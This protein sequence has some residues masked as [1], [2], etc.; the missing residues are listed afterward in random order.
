MSQPNIILL[1]C[2][3]LGR[4]LGCYGIPTVRTP[5][6][7][8][9]AGEGVRFTNAFCTA[10]LCSPSRAG[11]FTG[12]YPHQNGVMGL[13]GPTSGWELHDGEKHLAQ[14]LGEA[15]Y[16]CE[17][18]GEIHE[19]ALPP[20]RLGFVRHEPD[21]RARY[22]ADAAIERLQELAAGRE[23]FYLQVGC[24]EPHRIPS[25]RPDGEQ[26]FTGTYMQPDDSL[27]VTVPGYLK[28]TPGT[29]EELAELQGAV[30]HM[31]EHMGRILAA[32]DA[33][34]LAETTLVIFTTDHGIAMPRAKCSLYDPGIEVALLLRFRHA[35][36]AGG[37]AVNGLVSNLDLL[38][39]ILQTVGIPLPDGLE[40]RSLTPMLDGSARRL[41]DDVFA[42]LTY[43]GGFYHPMR[44][45]RTERYKLILNFSNGR[46]IYDPSSS[47]RPRSDT[48]FPV[49]P[50]F[51]SR[52]VMELY[53]L[54]AD[55]WEHRNLAHDAHMQ[56]TARQLLARMSEIMHKTHDPILDGP[57]PSAMHF[58]ALAA[59]DRATLS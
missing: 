47:L 33:L 41:R 52:T 34:G 27:G 21:K 59:L 53:D 9:L 44:C 50:I 10:S 43:V 51:Q 55:R 48:V 36:W 24:Y 2:H 46:T 58:Q 23:P 1:H 31:D 13:I 8:R 30:A 15:G 42:E 56:D 12:R 39:T 14:Y 32:V 28:D 17:A 7:N 16:H 38:P 22:V 29:R 3:D 19:S 4:F 11:M 54:A 25:G 37:R 5:N 18:V 20:A 45:L 6:L 57:I 35:G 40:G 26:Y 49:N